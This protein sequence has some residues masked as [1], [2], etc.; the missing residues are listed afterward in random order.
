MSVTYEEMNQAR[1]DFEDARIEFSK[2]YYDFLSTCIENAGF[3]NK[4]VQLKETD[5]RGVF[6]VDSE[7]S[8]RQPWAIKFFPLT[9]NG[10][11]SMKSK[12]LHNFCS[13]H[14]NTL[15]EQL[16]NLAEVVGEA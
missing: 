9:K 2:K 14:E 12:Y 13:W 11:V 3:K 15:T 10:D 8:T 5:I 16:L 7:S 1:R 4:L 6:K